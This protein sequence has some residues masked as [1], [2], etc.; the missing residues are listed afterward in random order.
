MM[1]RPASSEQANP[2]LLGDL[3]AE[4]SAESAPLLQFIVTNS[5][6]IAAV[7]VILLLALAGT[8]AWRWHA[9]SRADQ[10][11]DELARATLTTS[12]AE[13]LK[14]LSALAE[15]CPEEYRYGVL[16]ALARSAVEAGDFERAA[17]AYDEAAQLE[18]GH[19]MG[20][21]AELARAGVLLRAGKGE[22]ALTILQTLESGMTEES[23]LDILP[24]V[25]DAAELAGKKDAAAAA[26]ARLGEALPGEDGGFYRARAAELGKK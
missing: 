25:A 1:Q 2:T 12:G 22:Q 10:A 15:K 3:R 26:Y 16:S 24:L 9:A 14:A 11:L 7:V 21:A 13:R 23:R 20:L 4:V 8:G 6:A 19:P 17:A 18:K 5:K